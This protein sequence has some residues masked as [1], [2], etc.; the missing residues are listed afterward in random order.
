MHVAGSGSATLDGTTA[1]LTLPVGD[2]TVTELDGLN[3]NADE[4]NITVDGESKGKG[5][6]IQI[7]IS[8]LNTTDIVFEN[9]VASSNIPNDSSAVINGMQKNDDNQ[10]TLTFE[11][12]KELGQELPQTTTSD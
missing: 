12:K 10:F 2:Y 6:D 9:T 8:A 11:Q 5:S 7:W 1:Y 3:F 4:A